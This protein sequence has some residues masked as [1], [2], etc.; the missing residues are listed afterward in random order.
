MMMMLPVSC[1][2]MNRMSLL[3]ILLTPSDKHWWL[4][5]ESHGFIDDSGGE[6]Q[7]AD[8]FHCGLAIT[9]DSIDLQTAIPCQ[10]SCQLRATGNAGEHQVLIYLHNSSRQLVATGTIQSNML[11]QCRYKPH[12][13]SRANWCPNT[14][15]FQAKLC[16]KFN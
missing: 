7:A 12:R 11:Y 13:N 6:L 4:W 2:H 1:W 3:T 8:L 10:L 15:N 5:V 9:D 14:C 16:F